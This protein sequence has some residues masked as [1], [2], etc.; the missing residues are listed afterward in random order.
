MDP[1]LRR[2]DTAFVGA[3]MLPTHRVTTAYFGTVSPHPPGG[4][5]PLTGEVGRGCVSPDIRANR[6]P[7]QPSPR[8]GG[9][10]LGLPGYFPRSHPPRVTLGPDLRALHWRCVGQVKAPRVGPEG[11]DP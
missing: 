5:S 1:G 8:G 3:S 4:T 11:D 10:R 7:P 2:D 9:C 6:P